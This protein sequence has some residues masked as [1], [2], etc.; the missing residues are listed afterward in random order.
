MADIPL[1]HVDING[2]TL[3]YKLV[4]PADAPLFI[5]LHGGRGCGTHASDFAA[6]RALGSRFRVLSLDFRGHGASS[7]TPPYTF[8]QLVDDVEAARVHFGGGGRAQKAVICGGSFGGFLALQYAVKYPDSLSHLILR[9]T[10]PSHEHEA[11]A[12][13]ILES[14]LPRVPLA[15]LGMLRKVFGSFTDDTEFRLVMF[16]LGPLYSEGAYDPDRGLEGVRRGVYNAETHNAL[17]S[18]EEKYFDYR[19]RL[20]EITVPTLI[21]V[22]EKD[23]ICPLSQSKL[24]KA[25]IPDSKLLVFPDANHS[26]HTEKNAEVIAAIREFLDARASA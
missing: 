12:F 6:Y 18:E 4:G 2:A 9:G 17:Y 23:W 13:T 14:R 20:S 21:V 11:E 1:Q 8:A 7:L 15:S 5:T 22:G 26:V 24:L 25:G 19:D 3:A 16:A 10:A